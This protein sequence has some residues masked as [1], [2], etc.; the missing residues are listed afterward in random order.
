MQYKK[1]LLV[2][3]AVLAL[4]VVNVGFAQAVQPANTPAATVT[5]GNSAPVASKKKHKKKKKD[6]PPADAP[7]TK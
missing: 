1:I 6:A 5:T 3:A 2:L 7:P 4:E